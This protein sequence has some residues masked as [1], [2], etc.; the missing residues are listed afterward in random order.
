VKMNVEDELNFGI[1]NRCPWSSQTMLWPTQ[2]HASSTAG[3]YS[4]VWAW[5]VHTT[6]SSSRHNDCRCSFNVADII[7]VQHHT[8]IQHPTVTRCF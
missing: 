7:S 2:W 4:G 1:I 6:T 8:S 5:T 3:Q